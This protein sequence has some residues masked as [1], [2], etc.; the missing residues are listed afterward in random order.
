MNAT[1]AKPI[2]IPAHL[3]RYLT[4]LHAYTPVYLTQE[5]ELRWATQLAETARDPSEVQVHHTIVL[6][7]RYMCDN[8]AYLQTPDTDYSSEYEPADP[9]ALYVRMGLCGNLKQSWHGTEFAIS[10]KLQKL[11][12]I[13]GNQSYPFN[14]LPSHSD[15]FISYA[16]EKHLYN[17]MYTNP[18]RLQ[19]L[20]FL[21]M[22]PIY[23][24]DT[25]SI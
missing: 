23:L 18:L 8:L 3:Q 14:D 25:E 15:T 24:E 19:F 16:M 4:Q 13:F 5:I 7:A 1:Q 17:T 10:R 12:R 6:A 11:F 21:A 2:T 20:E 9:R 22:Q